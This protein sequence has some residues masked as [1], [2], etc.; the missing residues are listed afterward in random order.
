MQKTKNTVH[1]R[2]HFKRVSTLIAHINTLN[3]ENERLQ[4]TAKITRTHQIALQFVLAMAILAMTFMV[5]DDQATARCN[6]T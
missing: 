2:R 3:A 1:N 5:L 4:H 6:K